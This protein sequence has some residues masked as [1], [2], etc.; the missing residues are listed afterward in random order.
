[1][2]H[3]RQAKNRT[4]DEDS[5]KCKKKFEGRLSGLEEPGLGWE[6]AVKY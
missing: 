6:M 2:H 5:E 3:G 1:M 4:G